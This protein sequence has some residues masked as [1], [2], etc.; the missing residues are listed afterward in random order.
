[1]LILCLSMKILL[2]IHANEWQRQKKTL[3]SEW[4]FL[5]FCMSSYAD[6]LHV[7]PKCHCLIHIC[8][9]LAVDASPA[10]GLVDDGRLHLHGAA[11]A[12]R[13]PLREGRA[14]RRQPPLRMMYLT[15]KYTHDWIHPSTCVCVMCT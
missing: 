14:G 2:C 4:Q 3:F 11:G 6:L 1:M 8:P 10:P 9:I 7:C 15:V 12:G 5:P 13:G